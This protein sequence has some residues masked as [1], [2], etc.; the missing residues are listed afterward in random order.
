MKR[1]LRGGR[2]NPSAAAAAKAVPLTIASVRPCPFK[3]E[4]GTRVWLVTIESERGE[5]HVEIL[6]AFSTKDQAEWARDVWAQK[7]K[8]VGVDPT[9]PILFCS[10]HGIGPVVR[11]VVVES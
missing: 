8:W 11:E 1:K 9:I 5:P 3:V 6:T 7:H 2:R 10:C 4:A